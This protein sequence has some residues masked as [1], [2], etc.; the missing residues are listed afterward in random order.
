MNHRGVEFTVVEVEAGQWNWQFRIGEAV[1]AGTSKL[2]LKGLVVRRIQQRN[3]RELKKLRDLRRWISA[4]RCRPDISNHLRCFR[5]VI[6]NCQ[7]AAFPSGNIWAKQ[8]A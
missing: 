5:I 7:S 4:V 2:S 1:M 8:A 6:E 3:D